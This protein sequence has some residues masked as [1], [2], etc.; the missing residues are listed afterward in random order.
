MQARLLEALAARGVPLILCL[1]QLEVRDQP[2]V[3]RFNRREID[4]DTLAADIGWAKKWKN[5]ADY[6]PLVEF[7]QT[8]GI[9]VRA[10]N[11]PSEVIRAVHLAEAH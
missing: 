6:R 2:A 1:E 5:F 3:D 7:A 11:A 4:F 9:P 8:R 10:L